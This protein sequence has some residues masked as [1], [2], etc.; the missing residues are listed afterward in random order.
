MA[1]LVLHNVTLIDGTGAVPHT[2]VTI[3]I[4]ESKIEEIGPDGSLHFPEDSEV[5]DVAGKVV[6]PGIPAI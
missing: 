3:L 4:N 6:L 2:G 1:H 5:Y